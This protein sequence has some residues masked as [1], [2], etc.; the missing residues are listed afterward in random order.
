M[1]EAKPYL[2]SVQIKANHGWR[3]VWEVPFRTASSNNKHI[4]AKHAIKSYFTIRNNYRI[5][6]LILNKNGK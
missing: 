6:I 5:K 2:R 1:L 4:N 3:I